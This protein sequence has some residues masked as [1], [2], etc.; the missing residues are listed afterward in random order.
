MLGVQSIGFS[1]LFDDGFR[2]T[3]SCAGGAKRE[4]NGA[5]VFG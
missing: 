4:V 1:R 2:L 3:H 5:G